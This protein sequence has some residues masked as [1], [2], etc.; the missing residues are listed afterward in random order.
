MFGAVFGREEIW[1]DT[2]AG[3]SAGSLKKSVERLLTG[4]T[5]L[6]QRKS[7]RIRVTAGELSGDVEMID[8]GASA[9]D[10][11]PSGNGQERDEFP[12]MGDIAVQE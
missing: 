8:S 7:A 6:M 4:M 10:T 9:G 1:A 3:K 2:K 11:V 5:S 12:L